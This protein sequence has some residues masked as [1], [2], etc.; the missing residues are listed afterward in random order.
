MTDTLLT[1]VGV[2]LTPYSAR[3]LSQTLEPISQAASMRRTVN[4]SLIDLSA[5]EFRKYQSQIRCND[6][7]APALDGVWPGQ[8]VTVDCVAELSYLTSG[9]SPAR[10]VV[11]GSSRTVGSYTF[12]RPQLSMRITGFQTQY[13]EWGA[14][15]GWSLDLEEA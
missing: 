3:G 10:T 7:D 2:G 15:V 8:L 5:P 13:D 1:I 14:E 12:Y 6:L 4:G 9:G 11:S